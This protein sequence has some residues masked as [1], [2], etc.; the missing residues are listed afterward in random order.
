MNFQNQH[1]IKTDKIDDSNI[2]I[3]ELNKFT[4]VNFEKMAKSQN[5]II[6]PKNPLLFSHLQA[7]SG[8]HCDSKCVIWTDSVCHYQKY[9]CMKKS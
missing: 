7:Q 5:Y 9:L 6:N 4:Y 2:Q 3:S 8:V 1:H